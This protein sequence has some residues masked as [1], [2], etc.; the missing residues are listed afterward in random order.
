[1]RGLYVI[2][3]PRDIGSSGLVEVAPLGVLMQSVKA[4]HFYCP[5]PMAIFLGLN[6]KLP[7][8]FLEVASG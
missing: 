8:A 4:D 7:E 1:M 2:L 5:C 3:E 6:G